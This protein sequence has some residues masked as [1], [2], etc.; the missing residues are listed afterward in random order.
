MDITK[1]NKNTQKMDIMKMSVTI[2]L[3]SA[4]DIMLYWSS[5]SGS[6]MFY[7]VYERALDVHF[8]YV[9][10]LFVFLLL[11]LFTGEG[12]WMVFNTYR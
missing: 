3:R 7:P 10:F 1:W 11:L 2:N 6:L 5:F 8:V 4:L 12:V 9:L